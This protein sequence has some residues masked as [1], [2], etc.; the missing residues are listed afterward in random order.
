MLA[1]WREYCGKPESSA[2]LFRGVGVG[3]HLFAMTLR[4][5]LRA[6]GV[7]RPELFVDSNQKIEPLRFHDTRSTFVTWAKRDGRGQGWIVD[8]TGHL[9]DDMVARYTRAA[10]TL[11]DLRIVPFPDLTSAIPELAPASDCGPDGEVSPP[12]SHGPE[13]ADLSASAMPHT[14][15]H[16]AQTGCLVPH[17]GHCG[18]RCRGFESRYSP[19]GYESDPPSVG[20]PLGQA[21]GETGGQ[22]EEPPPQRPTPRAPSVDTVE[23]ALAASL[24]T[25]AALADALTAQGRIDEAL[26][27]L[28]EVRAIEERLGVRAP[29]NGD[30]RSSERR[31]AQLRRIGGGR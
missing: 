23:L 4:D 25:R 26:E 30:A 18:P 3:P 10:R 21:A 13:N 1:A 29:T 16:G 12:V 5:D 9:D 17:V 15:P 11:A 22:P 19:E 7:T 6:S 8:R 27:L 20:H 24:R 14:I 31:S 2:P 28:G